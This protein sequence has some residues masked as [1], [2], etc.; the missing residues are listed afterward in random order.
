MA[1]RAV[2]DDQQGELQ[3]AITSVRSIAV[4][5]APVTMTQIFAIFTSGSGPFLPG[6]PFVLSMGLMVVC[7]IVFLTRPRPVAA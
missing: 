5:A 3:G 6:A 2:G 1:S 4:I 7:G